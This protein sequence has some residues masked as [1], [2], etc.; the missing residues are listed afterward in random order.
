MKRDSP[1]AA[2]SAATAALEHPYHGMSQSNRVS[3]G[4][5]ASQQNQMTPLAHDFSP[6][7]DDVICGRGKKCYNH[8]GNAKFRRGVM[9]ML[10]EY[11]SAKAKLDKSGV[12]SR[13]MAEV[14]RA[15]PGGGFV[16]Q[17]ESGQWYEVGD[18]LAREKTS[19]AFR[20]ALHERYKSSNISKKKRRQQDQ[21][22]ASDK[23]Q[24]IA[25]TEQEVSM[26]LE[27]IS[28][29]LLGAGKCCLSFM[30]RSS[31]IVTLT[32]FL[33]TATA[34]SAANVHASTQPLAEF[35]RANI[36]MLSRLSRR[37]NRHPNQAARS[38]QFR[39]VEFPDPLFGRNRG[40]Q[41]INAAP[42]FT[43]A[44]REAAPS[45]PFS[46]LMLPQRAS[47]LPDPRGSTLDNEEALH[48]SLPAMHL[49]EPSFPFAARDALDIE[50]AGLNRSLPNL[51]HMPP[52]R[53]EVDSN[54]SALGRFQSNRQLEP[55]AIDP[56]VD[57][58]A[59]TGK[60]ERYGT[61][62]Y[63]EPDLKRSASWPKFA[64]SFNDDESSS[65]RD[66][67]A[68]LEKLTEHSISEGNPYEP[69]PLVAIDAKPDRTSSRGSP[70]LF[71]SADDTS[72][73]FAEG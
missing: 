72:Q 19:Q 47:S 25:R 59:S 2:S 15:S 7:V 4:S 65:S 35:N 51:D 64:S 38:S 22:N 12:L 44:R 20:D 66:L 40:L 36:D 34:V 17:D 21:A 30:S 24:R 8:I 56:R 11:S 53:I 27:R 28:N 23:A 33:F 10:D 70:F 5:S 32:N 57:P 50:L 18:F 3:A 73:E 62:K 52:Q 54:T 67:L 49:N 41:T 58:T 26:R 1:S 63:Q 60:L 6:S 48:S 31:L 9:A 68:C 13:V 42:T 29:Q 37:S 71:R 45:S 43:F 14:R 69:I 16:K 61:K 46:E 55:M 39:P